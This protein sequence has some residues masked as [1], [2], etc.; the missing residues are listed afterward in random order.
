MSRMA[1]YTLIFLYVIF[2]FTFNCIILWKF[3][4]IQNFFE[5]GF[6]LKVNLI[7]VKEVKFIIHKYLK[8]NWIIVERLTVLEIYI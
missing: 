1:H 6:K 7:F 8:T 5:G 4:Y 2:F 3:N